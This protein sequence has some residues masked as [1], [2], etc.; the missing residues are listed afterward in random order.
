MY[1]VDDRW[2]VSASDLVSHLNC[3]HHTTLSMRRAV[4]DPNADP[5]AEHV[6]PDVSVM[7]RRG[8]EHE[9]AHLAAL[10]ARGLRVVEISDEGRG[11]DA[12][13]AAEHRTIDAM[14]NGVDVIFQATFLDDRAAIMWRGHADFLHRVGSEPGPNGIW[15]YE[16]EDTKLARYVK[17]AT[18][19]QLANYAEHLERLQRS[20]PGSLHV[21]LVD[22]TR[23]SVELRK[24]SAY[25]RAVK[26][27]F[28]QKVRA[29]AGGGETYPLPVLHCSV[30]RYTEQCQQRWVDDDHLTL[31]ATV[32]KE[33][34]SKLERA[35]IGTMTA[36]GKVGDRR[37]PG[38]SVPTFA[39]LRAQARLQVQHRNAPDKPPPYELL[40]AVPGRGLAQLPAPSTGD[41]YFDIEGDPFVGRDG[42]EYLL[43]V[44]WID[45]DGQQ[46]DG[47]VFTAFWAHTTAEE[48]LSLEQFV[49][50]VC[51][52]RREFPDMH[53]Y[54]YA[55]YEKTA[56]GKLS[57]RH[58]TREAE[59]DDLFRG[60]VL[61]DLYRV[62][63]Q[64]VLIGTHSYS[65][66][67]LEPLYM[68][69]REANIASAMSSIVQYELWLDERRQAI[70][71]DIEQYNRDDCRSTWLLH[72][73]L[74]Q[75]PKPTAYVEATD[76]PAVR[77]PP[78][79]RAVDDLFDRLM[80]AL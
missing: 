21:Q 14:R 47:F 13:R 26:H 15:C 51:E 66:K 4:A 50:L 70:L 23:Q 46:S 32:G 62:V 16:P 1:R 48:K 64:A 36:L 30:C 68:E 2:V 75:L 45:E 22:N 58:R 74:Q 38:M 78:D 10:K 54:H 11:L 40:E 8:D 69:K 27:R 63:Q 31:V 33:Q 29:G 7:Q 35:G 49:D 52:R 20:S 37:V 80:V 5:A 12:L 59:V 25:Y 73:W 34:T 44:G 79:R 17:A 6:D 41:L 60:E 53:V 28:E 55:A 67:R 57:G 71:D 18:V 56:L 42:L 77:V 19:L 65:I 9:K 76:V 43:G 39:R 72:G 3:A 61:V 24:V